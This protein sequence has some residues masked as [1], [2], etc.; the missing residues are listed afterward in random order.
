MAVGKFYLHRCF[1]G[2][3]SVVMAALLCTTPA[4]AAVNLMAPGSWYLFSKEKDAAEYKVL[5]DTSFDVTVKRAN[6]ENFNIQVG[7][8]IEHEMPEGQALRVRF[9]A[10]AAESN[11]VIATVEKTTEPYTRAMNEH[12]HLTPR[13]KAY[14][15]TCFVPKYANGDASLRF[16]VADHAGTI[17]FRAI[18][19]ELLSD[20]AFGGGMNLLSDTQINARIER[21]RKGN[22]TV[23][24]VN[25]DNNKPVANASVHVQQTRHQFLFGCN[26]FG[27]DL[28]GIPQDFQFRHAAVLLG[29]LRISARAAQLQE[30]G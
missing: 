10:R 1:A 7:H 21:Y 25:Q 8:R 11:M 5:S 28:Q 14:D 9:E 23:K 26:I 6:K 16:M 27:L 13:W 3:I 18:D 4:L 2:V 22:L 17:E 19:I 30:I 12:I 15:F 20:A 24:I 29:R